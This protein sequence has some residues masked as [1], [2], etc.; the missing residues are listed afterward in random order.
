ME[1]VKWVNKTYIK[2]KTLC[3]M[4]ES[5]TIKSSFETPGDEDLSLENYMTNV[6]V[7]VCLLA[8]SAAG[9]PICS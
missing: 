4:T 5:K 9:E 7:C 6:C 1:G 2:T 8:G 3:F